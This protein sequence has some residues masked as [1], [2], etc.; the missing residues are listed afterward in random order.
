MPHHESS[1]PPGVVLWGDDHPTLGETAVV[2][3]N[4]RC[5]IGLSAGRL[6]KP[7]WHLDPNEDNALA[8]G[9]VS[10]RLLAVADGHNGIDAARA[11]VS[12]IRDAAPTMVASTARPPELLTQL[13]DRAAKAVTTAAA[14][15]DSARSDS[16]TALSIAVLNGDRLH[17][18]TFGD[19]VIARVRGSKAK[20][21]TGESPFLG[22]T[23]TRPSLGSVR[24]RRGDLV[25]L[26]S[27]GVTDFLGSRPL[28]RL[29]AALQGIEEP[30][31]GVRRL[32]ELA[33]AGGAGDHLGVALAIA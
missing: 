12:G 3:L 30:A 16:A 9:T 11:A 7:Y 24:V 21:V 18:A 25:V 17:A 8:L 15:A 20:R 19:T 22:P 32:L 4:D 29:G 1:E 10:L 23:G 28:E 27:D 13:I 31:D 6:P 26:T 14:N 33:M 5:A 2:S